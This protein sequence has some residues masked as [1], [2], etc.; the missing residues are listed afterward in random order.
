MKILIPVLLF[1]L[2]SCGSFTDEELWIKIEQAK[3]NKNWEFVPLEQL[4][5]NIFYP[6]R[7]KRD[8][9]EHFHGAVP[10][11]SFLKTGVP[12]LS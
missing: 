10:L 7:F 9:V 12:L 11:G 8:Y 6:I 2:N 3:A 1:L 4:V 5:K